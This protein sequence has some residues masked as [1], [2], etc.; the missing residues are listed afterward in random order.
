MNK[1]VTTEE[2]EFFIYICLHFEVLFDSRKAEKI[3]SLPCNEKMRQDRIGQAST[4]LK[5]L[6]KCNLYAM[7]N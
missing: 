3:I 4:F 7:A 6:Q 2:Y 1:L 5:W